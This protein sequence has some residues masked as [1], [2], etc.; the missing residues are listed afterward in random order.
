M[1]FEREEE[2]IKSIRNRNGLIDHGKLM[3]KTGVKERE[4]N[5]GLN[6]KYFFNN[7]LGNVQKNFI[8][9]K[10]NSKKK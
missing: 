3:R 2:K 10:N 4:I 9:S 7:D 5:R 1:K 6:K 8:K